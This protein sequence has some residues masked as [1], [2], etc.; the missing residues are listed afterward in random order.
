MR[1]A[2]ASEGLTD[3]IVLK[4][5]LFGFFKNKSLP[6]TP[7]RPKDKLPFGWSNLLNYISSQDFKDDCIDENIDYVIIQ[8]DTKECADWNETLINIGDDSSQ[9]DEFINKTIAVL[10]RKIGTDFY[11]EHKDKIHFAI[12]VHDLECW[13]LPFNAT[14]AAHHSKIVGCANTIEQIAQKSGYSI[15]QKN[16]ENGKHYD[17]LSKEMKNNK[18]LLQK[19]V[20]NPSLKIFIES[21]TDSFHNSMVTQN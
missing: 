7:L 14:H 12:C 17:T 15:N 10:I 19:G 8:I 4:N 20:L 1:F 18:E 2:I 16:Y 13:L 21:L 11:T 6:V 3:F 9:M 5:L